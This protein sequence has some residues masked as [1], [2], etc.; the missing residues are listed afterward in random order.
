MPQTAEQWGMSVRMPKTAAQAAMGARLRLV[1]EIRGL[2]QK[3]L[4]EVA[5][6]R[7]TAIQAWENGRNSIDPVALGWMAEAL[8]VTTDFIILDNLQGV[9]F[10]LAV[11]IQQARRG[12]LDARPRRG[13]PKSTPTVRE[14]PEVRQT[15]AN[16]PRGRLHD[17]KAPRIAPP[18]ARQNKPRGV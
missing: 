8:G 13:R 10:E 14:A 15:E 9:A 2:T 4:G 18:G 5:G 16:R 11:K 12:E 3:A 7:D 6:T 17:A 1:R